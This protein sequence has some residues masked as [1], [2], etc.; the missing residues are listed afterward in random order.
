[1]DFKFFKGKPKPDSTLI[2]TQLL[3]YNNH[4]N[5]E[6]CFQFDDDEPFAFGNGNQNLILT[7][8][9]TEGGSVSFNHN[10]RTF[11]IFARE[12]Q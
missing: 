2:P 11:K 1:M 3:T 9:P 10:G 5:N 12:R 4:T 7:I 8:T 6:Y